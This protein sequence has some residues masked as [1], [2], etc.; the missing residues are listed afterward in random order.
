MRLAS[1]DMWPD[2]PYLENLVEMWGG[3]A[4]TNAKG[5]FVTGLMHDDS[6]LSQ[7]AGIVKE[8]HHANH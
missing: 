1:L 8:A 3:M 5:R 2:Q 7:I 4:P 6:H